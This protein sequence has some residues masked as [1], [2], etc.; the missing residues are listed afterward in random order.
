MRPRMS[1]LF[2][3]SETTADSPKLKWL[4]KH[5]LTVLDDSPKGWICRNGGWTKAVH[6]DT[7]DEAIIN[8]C[9]RYDVKH[10]T[11]EDAP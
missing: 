10:W 6:G 4:K 8:Y 7:E 5:K 3:E 9:E 2:P 1:E 11:L